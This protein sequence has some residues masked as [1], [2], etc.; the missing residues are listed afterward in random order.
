[1]CLY[2]CTNRTHIIIIIII[3]VGTRQLVAW[4]LISCKGRPL[5]FLYIAACF[6][7]F[8]DLFLFFF[9]QKF[10][11]IDRSSCAP[12]ACVGGQCGEKVEERPRVSCSN[13]VRICTTDDG[14]RQ[15]AN[16]PI[17]TISI[18]TSKSL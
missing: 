15:L 16:G 11:L 10:H 8:C 6:F 12:C 1:M 14:Q 9:L 7:S 18:R 3:P 13:D 4:R 17:E 5:F 2:T